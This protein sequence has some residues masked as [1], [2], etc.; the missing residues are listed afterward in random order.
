[1]ENEDCFI[2]VLYVKKK[3]INQ[4]KY[5]ICIYRRLL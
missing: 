1:M 3:E 5:I 4:G 2:R